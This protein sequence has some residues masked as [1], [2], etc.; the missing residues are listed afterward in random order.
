MNVDKIQCKWIKC[1]LN[2]KP[3]SLNMNENM[4]EYLLVMDVSWM[5]VGWWLNI[6]LLLHLLCDIYSCYGDICC[7]LRLFSYMHVLMLFVEW[8]V[9]A[10]RVCFAFGV[11]F[12]A[13]LAVYAR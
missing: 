1:D 4:N 13:I 8:L 11:R 2:W 12:S 3:N 6:L 7:I 9:G 10:D 5:I